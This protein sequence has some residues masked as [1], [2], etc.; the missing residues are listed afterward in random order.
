LPTTSTTT[1]RCGL[2]DAEAVGAVVTGETLG[3][4]T[5]VT[6]AAGRLDRVK[7]NVRPTAAR[8]TATSMTRVR[9]SKSREFTTPASNA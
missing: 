1:S 7:N 9:R 3:A 4:A 2:A 5:A 6:G 8:N